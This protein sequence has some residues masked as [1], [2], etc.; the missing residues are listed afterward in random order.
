MSAFLLVDLTSMMMKNVLTAVNSMLG[1]D[2]T[3]LEIRYEHSLSCRLK[4]FIF[5]ELLRDHWAGEDDFLILVM[6]VLKL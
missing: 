2:W 3:G 5:P 6:P 1:D 4:P